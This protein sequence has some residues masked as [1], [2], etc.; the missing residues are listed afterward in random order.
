MYSNTQAMYF[1][2]VICLLWFFSKCIINKMNNILSQETEEISMKAWI[3]L[4]RSTLDDNTDQA[5]ASEKIPAIP[6]AQN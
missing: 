3:S 5:H 4:P 6:K 2:E 1:P